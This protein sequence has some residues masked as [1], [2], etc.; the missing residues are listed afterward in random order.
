MAADLSSTAGR[1]S[2]T[3]GDAVV[4]TGDG[5]A[6]AIS[7]GG[8]GLGAV[9]DE[10]GYNIAAVGDGTA[11]ATSGNWPGSESAYA[12]DPMPTVEGAPARSRGLDGESA[13]AGAAGGAA[14]ACA[15]CACC[16]CCAGCEIM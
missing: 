13:A 15:A 7:N 1:I 14:G 11:H 8:S 5:V 2:H 10:K 3:L 4:N 16:A 6:D 12:S 9:W